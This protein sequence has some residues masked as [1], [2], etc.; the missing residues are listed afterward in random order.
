MSGSFM[1]EVLNC[2][3]MLIKQ[4][5]TKIQERRCISL[6]LPVF[7]SLHFARQY[8]GGTRRPYS[9]DLCFMLMQVA[10]R[11]RSTYPEGKAPNTALWSFS[12]AQALLAAKL[13][14]FGSLRSRARTHSIRVDLSQ[15]Q[16]LPGT[17]YWPPFYNFGPYLS[18]LEL[19]ASTR[20]R[21][22][23]TT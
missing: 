13:L 15:S 10:P 8:L 4:F 6:R 7:Y 14:A 20:Y 12:L 3:E 21:V 9:A 16:C 11:A 1:S 23:S 2:Y 5:L 19:D 17:P 22:L 18:P